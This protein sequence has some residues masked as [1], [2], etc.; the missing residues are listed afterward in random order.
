MERKPEYAIRRAATLHSKV[1]AQWEVGFGR[2]GLIRFMHGACW[3]FG[4]DMTTRSR[5]PAKS[6]D[7]PK[8]PRS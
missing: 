7:T 2:R 3:V 5:S 8:T 1:F 6:C 4:D